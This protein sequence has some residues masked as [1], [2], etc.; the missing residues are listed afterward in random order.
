MSSSNPVLLTNRLADKCVTFLICPINPGQS[1]AS[2]STSFKLTVPPGGSVQTS[3]ETTEGGWSVA[4]IIESSSAWGNTVTTASQPI[5][6]GGANFWVDLD[7][8]G[9][10]VLSDQVADA[11][12]VETPLLDRSASWSDEPHEV[13]DNVLNFPLQHQDQSEW[14]WAAVTSSVSKFYDPHSTYTQSNLAVWAFGATCALTPGSSICNRPYNMSLSLIHTGNGPAAVRGA[15]DIDQIKAEID[16]N[17]PIGL[18]IF[19]TNG[20]GGHAITI[21]GYDKRKADSPMIQVQDPGDPVGTVTFFPLHLFPQHYSGGADWRLSFRTHTA[22]HAMQ[23]Q[24]T[25]TA[26]ER[27]PTESLT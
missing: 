2:S 23:E 18:G 25:A 21:T 4:A 10:Y 1:A 9:D 6:A 8:S 22:A 24:G 17:H 7:A 13:D 5:P 11:V 15:F 16:G 3:E 19:W 20:S 12:A 27:I 26:I 14:C